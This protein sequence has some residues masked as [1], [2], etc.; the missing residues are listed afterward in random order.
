MK[1]Q[2][3][4][5]TTRGQGRVAERADE[6]SSYGK[7]MNNR[8]AMDTH[9]S[10]AHTRLRHHQLVPSQYRS[11]GPWVRGKKGYAQAVGRRGKPILGFPL[12]L[13]WG[14]CPAGMTY[15]LKEGNMSWNC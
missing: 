12:K 9:G 10:G 11:G 3:L 1:A 5:H 2:R 7:C 15:H 4:I 14:K 6:P 13:F 8:Q